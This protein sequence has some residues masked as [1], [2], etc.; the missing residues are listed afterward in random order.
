M[1]V[2]SLAFEELALADVSRRAGVY[3][4]AQEWTDVGSRTAVVG[5]LR[6]S[7]FT[8]SRLKFGRNYESFEAEL[9]SMLMR[10][11]IVNMC[12]RHAI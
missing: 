12:L 5:S 8:T 2:C 9:D 1:E 10:M 4:A 11:V 3:S 7:T 6:G